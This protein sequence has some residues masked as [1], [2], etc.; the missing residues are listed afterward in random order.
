MTAGPS[1]VLRV[2]RDGREL[3]RFSGLAPGE[4]L[5]LE[6]E[7]VAEVVDLELELRGPQGTLASSVRVNGGPFRGAQTDDLG[8]V[9]AQEVL[10][11]RYSLWLQAPGC[12]RIR[13]ELEVDPSEAASLGAR[14]RSSLVVPALRCVEP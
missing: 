10:P 11:G 13:V 14:V 4:A 12:E 3:G 9:E 2:I 7:V 6:L 1:H 5:D 8:R